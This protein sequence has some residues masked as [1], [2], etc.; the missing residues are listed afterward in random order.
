M[1]KRIVRGKYRA[2]IKR[3][4]AVA[5][6][7]TIKGCPMVKTF[8]NAIKAISEIKSPQLKWFVKKQLEV[9]VFGNQF[10]RVKYKVMS[11]YNEEYAPI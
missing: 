7:L 8:F 6:Y 5:L 9:N 10:K 4:I 1:H 11:M 2:L 3:N